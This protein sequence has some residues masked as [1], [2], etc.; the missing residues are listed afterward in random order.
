[1]KFRPPHSNLPL[2]ACPIPPCNVSSYMATICLHPNRKKKDHARQQSRPRNRLGSSQKAIHRP[3][4]THLHGHL[5]THRATSLLRIR[6][7][8]PMPPPAHAS[9]KFPL[10]KSPQR[11]PSHRPLLFPLYP[12]SP[13]SFSYI[14]RSRQPPMHQVCNC[15]TAL[16]IRRRRMYKA[17]M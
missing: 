16:M 15:T 2:R 10:H 14:L 3:D 11:R 1:M 9:L 7:P 17:G 5:L 6:A 4:L 8:N 12:N 13:A